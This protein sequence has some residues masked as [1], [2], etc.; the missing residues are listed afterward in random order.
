VLAFVLLVACAPDEGLTL[1]DPGVNDCLVEELS[2]SEASEEI[3]L[4]AELVL[5]TLLPRPPNS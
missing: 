3:G 2:V 4:D 5:T 1:E